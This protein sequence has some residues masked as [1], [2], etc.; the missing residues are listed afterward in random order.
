MHVPEENGATVS[1]LPLAPLPASVEELDGAPFL[2]TTSTPVTGE[3]DAVAEL[4]RILALLVDDV[5]PAAAA[6]S[7]PPGIRLVIE[8]GGPSE[9]YTLDAR[10]GGVRVTAGSTPRSLAGRMEAATSAL[11]EAYRQG[12]FQPLDVARYA[13]TDVARAHHDIARRGIA[14]SAILMP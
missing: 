12:V 13:L 8:A 5:E 6:E 1:A 9:S 11:F 14:G 7:T 3:A 4:H 2:V 10:A